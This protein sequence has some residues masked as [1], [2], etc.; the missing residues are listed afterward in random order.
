MSAPASL[1]VRVLTSMDDVPQGAWDA[2]LTDAQGKPFVEWRWLR[3]LEVS[4]S[5]S[6]STGFWPRHLTL[7]RG[8]TLVA[9]APGYL[10]DRSLGEYLWDGDWAETAQRAGIAYYPKWVLASPLSPLTSSRFLVAPG[11][12]RRVLIDHL[13]R[14]ALVRAREA[15]A[16]GV[17]A[18]FPAETESEV[19][20]AWGFGVRLNVQYHWERD[21]ESDFEGFLNRLTSKRRNQIHRERRALGAQGISIRTVRGGDLSLVDPQEAYR[22]H[23]A[24]WEKHGS[25]T[26]LLTPTFFEQAFLHL[27]HRLEWVEARQGDNLVGAA[28]NVADDDVLY[29]R[30]WGSHHELPFLHFN[31]CL[32]HPIEECLALGRKRFEPGAGGEHK[33]VRGFQPRLTASAHRIFHPGLE[34]A[35]HGYLALERDAVL[36]GLPRWARESGL[37]TARGPN[38]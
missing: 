29:G 3:T 35:V 38:Q 9:A 6:E 11:E 37:K 22:H 26:P 8:D 14:E 10:R 2:L 33:L 17:H 19:L 16:S 4:G 24:T 36:S 34:R 28:W 21:G 31:V 13:I 12:N 20:Q 1:A 30:Y 32:Y 5:V 7:W 27:R 15:G 18:L 23:A 25:G